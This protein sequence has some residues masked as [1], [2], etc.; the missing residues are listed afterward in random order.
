MYL[1]ELA[2]VICNSETSVRMTEEENV[3][4]LPK[5]EPLFFG[6]QARRLVITLTQKNVRFVQVLFLS[7]SNFTSLLRSFVLQEGIFG[8]NVTICCQ[9]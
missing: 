6:C 1:P 7:T 8:F 4:P 5:V 3:L 9:F 2:R